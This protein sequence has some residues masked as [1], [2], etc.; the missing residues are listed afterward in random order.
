MKSQKKKKILV[1]SFTED[2]AHLTL[3]K[4]KKNEPREKKEKK[5]KTNKAKL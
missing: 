4:K 5:K 3:G 2:Q 1:A